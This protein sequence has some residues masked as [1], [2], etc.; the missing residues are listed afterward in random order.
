[1]KFLS[2]LLIGLFIL[3]LTVGILILAGA[4]LVSSIRES[5]DDPRRRP[6][7]FERVFAANVDTLN[8][9]AI[10]PTI[11]TFGTV[12]SSRSIEIRTSVA[13]TL[14][15]LS[16]LFRDGGYVT[17][18]DLVFQVDPAKSQSALALANSQMVE[19]QAELTAAVAALGLADSEV[20]IAQT[21]S[22]L[23]QLALT[24]EQS[25]EARGIGTGVAV[26]NAE[27][28]LASAEQALINQKQALAQA[29]TRIW[30][31]EAAL[32]RST[33]ALTDA[34]RN[35]EE[36]QVFAPFSGVLGDVSGVLGRLVSNNEKLAVLIDPTAMEVE[37]RLSYSQFSRLVDADGAIAQSRIVTR[38]GRDDSA[39][40]IG[41]TIVRI[42]AEVGEGQTGRLLYAQ[43]DANAESLIIPGDFLEIVVE[44]PVLEGV[45][46][47]P[48]SAVN[49]DGLM[50]LLGE[51]D[52]LEEIQ[53]NVLRRQGDLIIIKDVPFGREYISERSAQ[54]GSGIQV[55][56]LR[57]GDEL[58]TPVVAAAPAAPEMIALDDERRARLISAVEANKRMPA[59][60]KTRI[61][62]QLNAPE[63]SLEV[64]ERL[65]SRMRN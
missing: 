50:L 27:Q 60:A 61:L 41:A 1:M 46:Q 9:E 26:E 12:Q 23:R 53:V 8:Q 37:F 51:N 57:S 28:T 40:E 21:Q 44:E 31:A 11:S 54:L 20:E 42:G 17:A 35:L 48:A 34:E 3:T 22:N 7:G 55:K 16:P 49:S 32:D 38:F 29:N 13:G 18:G 56:P 39:R 24:R 45:A 19:A 5:D 58:E 6:G 63:V 65:E 59:E 25:L 62:T 15:K 47:I 43:L 14:V 10:A 52:R 36:T 2:R 33:I 64:V 30:R 4:E